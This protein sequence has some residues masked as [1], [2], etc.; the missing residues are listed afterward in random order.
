M[1]CKGLTSQLGLAV[2]AVLLLALGAA[3]FAHRIPSPQNAALDAY[4]LAGGDIA[5]LCGKTGGGRKTG[6]TECPVCQMTGAAA[7]PDPVSLAHDADLVVVVAV[8]ASRESRAARPVRDPG[9][10]LRAPPPV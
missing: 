1:I 2:V 6:L 3:A 9:R 4:V 10:G 7:L 5:T 8:L